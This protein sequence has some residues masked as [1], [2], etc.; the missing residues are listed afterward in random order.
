MC[1]SRA[2]NGKINRQHHRCLRIIYS[3]CSEK[4]SLFETLLVKNSS[5]S[6]HNG[7]LQILA[8]EM[9]KIKNDLCLLIETEL[10][11]QMNEQH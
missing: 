2:N 11:E 5:V 1:H 9:Y 8:A 7:N 6:V 4:Q 10:F 3:I